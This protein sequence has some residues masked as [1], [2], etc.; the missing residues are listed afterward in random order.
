MPDARKA[1]TSRQ[2]SGQAGA[3]FRSCARRSRGMSPAGY[4]WRPDHPSPLTAMLQRACPTRCHLPGSGAQRAGPAS[5][6]V[7]Y[8]FSFL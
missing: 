1:G 4:G 2:S 7:K 6:K 5:D 8:K 3:S